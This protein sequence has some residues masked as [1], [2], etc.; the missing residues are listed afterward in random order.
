MVDLIR[1]I[2]SKDIR[3]KWILIA[4]NVAMVCGIVATAFAYK[5]QWFIP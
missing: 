2:N 5:Y 3:S 4:F 1:T